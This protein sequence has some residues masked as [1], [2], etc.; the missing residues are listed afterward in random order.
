LLL[1]VIAIA[2]GTVVTAGILFVVKK[3]VAEING[4]LA[5]TQAAAA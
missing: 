5:D 4:Q 1:C 3:P 2:V